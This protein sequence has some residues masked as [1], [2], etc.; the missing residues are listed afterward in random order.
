[1]TE[2][3][4]AQTIPAASDLV[5][6]TPETAAAEIALLKKDPEFGKKLLAGDVAS[7]ERWTTLHKAVALEPASR[8]QVM[9][10]A[11]VST[12]KKIAD[13]PDK[14]WDDV[15]LGTAVYPHER[16]KAEQTRKQ[17]MADRPFLA[18][19]LQGDREAVSKMTLVNLILAAPVRK[20]DDK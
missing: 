5:K 4:V 11:Q 12:L 6:G 3:A 7:N 2:A 13:L 9:R 20:A 8:E 1:M 18:R 19:Y 17:L 10:E 14:V 16:E 15:R